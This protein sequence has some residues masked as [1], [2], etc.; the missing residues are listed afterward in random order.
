VRRTRL[1]GNPGCYPTCVILGLAP[2]AQAGLLDPDSVIADCKSGA[3]GA[4]RQALLG[5][6][7]C[8]VNDGFRAYKV[9][10]HRHTPEMEQELSLLAGTPV[11][12]TFT[13][14][15]V[16]M[17]RGILGTL[18]ASLTAPRSEDDLRELYRKFY[19]GHPFVRLHPPG[20]LPDTR[21]VRGANFCDLALRVDRDGRRV[22]VISAIDNLTKGAA[23]QAVQNFNL[24]VGFPETLGL[25]TPPFLP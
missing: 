8:E 20:S 2:L 18:Y 13:P 10:E 16:P 21:D 22:I 17:S 15:L 7:F 6:S 14:H 11:K 19:Q 5:M 9:L 25:E 12:V 24:M 23:G 1:V 3:S 4:G